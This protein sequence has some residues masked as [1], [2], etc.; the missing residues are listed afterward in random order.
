MHG[1]AEYGG[2]GNNQYLSG[3]NH[4][5][6]SHHASHNRDLYHHGHHHSSHNLGPGHHGGAS[7]MGYNGSI[8]ETNAIS[9]GAIEE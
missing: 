8:N 5:S 4:H 2:R 7:G 3:N 1:H 6:G 9:G